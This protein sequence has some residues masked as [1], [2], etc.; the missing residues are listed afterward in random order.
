MKNCV[1]I[2]SFRLQN[3]RIHLTY[4][5]HLNKSEYVDWLSGK[6]KAVKNVY[7]AH[8]TGDKNHPYDHTHVLIEYDKLLQTT[9]ARYFDYDDVHPNITKVVTQQHWANSLKYLAKEDPDNK[10]ML[11]L[12][13][14]ASLLTQVVSCSTEREAVEK[15]VL[16]PTDYH[17]VRD[18]YRDQK[19]LC[20]TKK[21]LPP[22]ELRSWQKVF[23]AVNEGKA[24]RAVNWVYDRKGRGGKSC[25]ASY[26]VSQDPENW[27]VLN[28]VGRVQDF[29]QNILLAVRG[30]WNSY[31]IILDLPRSC[32]LN[33]DL[34]TC[35]ES[36]CDARIT[37]TK[38]TG[39]II[40]L[41]GRPIVW[42]LSNS[43]PNAG[44]M[45][46]DRWRVLEIIGRESRGVA[47]R[48]L[49]GVD[50]WENR[51]KIDL[52]APIP[53]SYLPLYDTSSSEGSSEWVL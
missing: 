38:Y 52:S 36:V 40:E 20:E 19:P 28:S 24:E 45:S 9:R 3:K 12:P 8:E 44:K 31:G 37:C 29:S 22:F 17:G 39:G 4:K 35:L 18:M 1:N 14:V 7:L 13:A 10:F 23:L 26:L 16:K 48:V 25:W 21:P 46:Y 53:Y 11:E 41:P 47:L 34:Y 33:D 42:V 5:G 32:K 2:M 51:A 15:Y 6:G 49:S 43:L 50:G 27:L 30:G